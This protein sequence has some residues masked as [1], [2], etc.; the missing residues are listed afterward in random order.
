VFGQW[1]EGREEGGGRR[2][3]GGGRRKEGGRRREG[4]RG[5]T[6]G[7][8]G[9]GEGTT[10]GA[11]RERRRCMIRRRISKRAIYIGATILLNAPEEEGKVIGDDL[12]QRQSAWLLTC[13]LRPKLIT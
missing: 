13:T 9:E 1:G 2:K 5:R 7:K 11:S 10:R 6:G 3:E 12:R 4:E 8:G